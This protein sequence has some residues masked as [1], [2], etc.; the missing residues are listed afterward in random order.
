MKRDTKEVNIVEKEFMEM[1]QQHNGIIYKVAYFY[2]SK[3]SVIDDLYQEI[4]LNLWRAFPDFKGNS[5]RSTWVYR[6]ALNT[7]ISFFRRSTKRPKYVELSPEMKAVSED[8]SIYLKELYT[9]I[10]QLNKLER[11]IIL[12]YLDDRPN[13]EIAEI[14][15]ITVSN[16]S[17]KINRI[18]E[19]LMKMSNM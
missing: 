7:C 9:L 13:K 14:M 10:G 16:T 1:I 11:A 19:K 15:G 17:T 12:L 8:N 5:S 18:K 4:V 6:V 2:Q 3:E